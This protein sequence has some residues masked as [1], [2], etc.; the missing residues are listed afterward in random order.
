MMKSFVAVSLFVAFAAFVRADNM[1]EIDD[2]SREPG[3]FVSYLFL[4]F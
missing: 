4:F 2:E 3:Y 1:A